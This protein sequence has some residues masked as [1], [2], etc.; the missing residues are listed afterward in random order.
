MNPARAWAMVTVLALGSIAT[1]TAATIVN[2]ALPS[3]IGALGLGQDEAQWLSTAFL[4]ASTGCMLLNT[5]AVARM[6]MRSAFAVAMAAFIAGS[7]LGAIAQDLWLLVAG[8]VMQGA[9]AGLIQPMAMLVIYR[10]FPDGTRGLAIG[11]YSLC[12]I[13]SPA[14][15]P[16]AGGAMIEAHDWR[17][18]FIATVPL[19]L[20]AIPLGFWLLPRREQDGP[21]RLDWPGLVL[22]M[23][24]ITLALQ[25][26]QHGAREG[27][28]DPGT[29]LRLAGAILT[30]LAFL[31]WEHRSPSPLLDLRLFA[32]PGFCMAGAAIFLTGAGVYGSTWAAPLFVQLIQNYGPAGAGEILLPAGVAMA[33]CFPLAG[34]LSDRLDAR[35]LIAA[36]ALMTGCSMLMLSEAGPPT[37]FAA[38]AAALALGRAGYG[39]VMPAANASA[40]RHAAGK[41]AA[42]APAATFLSQTGGALGVAAVSA[43]L[44]HRTA[45]HAD[46]LA[47]GMNADAA[48][49]QLANG[50][51]ETG[52][53]G[54]ESAAA[55][56]AQASRS[57]GL[58][59]QMLAFRDCFLATAFAG[60]LLLPIGLLSPADR[61][62]FTNR[63]KFALT[64]FR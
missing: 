48:L 4:A 9:G 36:G 27:W 22:V 56:L 30:T 57:L 3:V 59:A 25:T 60:F 26:F 49:A 63:L 47:S 19:A 33:V 21:V 16:V 28:D 39:A 23:V 43:L 41:L 10:H 45:F 20:A 24:A 35:V 18:I 54:P 55:A 42:A 34:R 53:S 14:F 58:T 32:A 1:M 40:M 52:L 8:R 13:V 17:I 11:L 38:I 12:V 31:L 50:F 6:G 2:V 62:N 64:L 15:G 61:W 51:R 37:E 44:Q 46:A 29:N 7:A 5:W